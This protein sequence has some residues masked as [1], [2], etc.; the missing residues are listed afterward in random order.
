MGTQSDFAVSLRGDMYRMIESLSL[1]SLVTRASLCFS[2]VELF[3]LNSSTCQASTFFSTRAALATWSEP[4]ARS[5]T[6][7]IEMPR[8]IVAMTNAISDFP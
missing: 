4:R 6:S 8:R 2:S 1:S 5:G 7:M 3:P